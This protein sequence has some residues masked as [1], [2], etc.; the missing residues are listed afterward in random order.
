MS[1]ND[2]PARPD[3]RDVN[4]GVI[5]AYRDE[6]TYERDGMPLVLLTTT[7]RR[8]GK[9]HTTPVAVQT[10][11]DR[12]IVAGTMGGLPRHPQWYLNLQA[13]PDL[14]V[15]FRGDRYPAR[16]ST[17]PP[18]PE[19]DRLAALMAESLP[20]LPRYEAKAAASRQVPIVLIERAG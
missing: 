13:T 16:A 4:A 17:V 1:P 9:Q 11:G 7:G 10:D 18:G 14:T 6:Q 19:R 2:K 12:L 5:K 3:I 20:E 8:S 15:E